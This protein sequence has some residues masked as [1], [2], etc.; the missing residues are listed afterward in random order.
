[1]C[2]QILLQ[3]K[4]NFAI[5][6][7]H[8]RQCLRETRLSSQ[9]QQWHPV[10]LRKNSWMSIS[11]L[12]IE[13]AMIK[14]FASPGVLRTVSSAVTIRFRRCIMRKSLSWCCEATR[15]CRYDVC[16]WTKYL[17]VGVCDDQ[18]RHLNHPSSLIVLSSKENNLPFWK[19]KF[20]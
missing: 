19:F 16:Y 2:L 10:P 13:F 1:L 6:V 5:S 4:Y 20:S 15:V 14:T 17:F 11:R 7:Y 3:D 12:M 18:I 9:S 8:I